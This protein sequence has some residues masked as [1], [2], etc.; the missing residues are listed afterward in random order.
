M[1]ANYLGDERD[2]KPLIVGLKIIR[3]IYQTSTFKEHVRAESLTGPECVTDRDYEQYI[4]DLSQTIFH[5]VGTCRMGADE[6]GV[7]DFAYVPKG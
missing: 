2:V 7:V 5:P 4:R 6:Y 3:Q 1:F